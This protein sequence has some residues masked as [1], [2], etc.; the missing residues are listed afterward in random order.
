M[1]ANRHRVSSG[2]DGNVLELMLMATQLCEY[3]K[4]HRTVHFK[5]IKFMVCELYLNQKNCK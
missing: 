3:T 1:T 5:R 4:Y 2:G